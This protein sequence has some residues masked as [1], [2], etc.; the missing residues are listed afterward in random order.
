MIIRSMLSLMPEN[1][2]RIENDLPKNVV[3]HEVVTLRLA[4]SAIARVI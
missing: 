1:L 3:G 2:D 4:E